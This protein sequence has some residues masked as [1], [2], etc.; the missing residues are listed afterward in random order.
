[1]SGHDFDGSVQHSAG[2][3]TDSTAT[4]RIMRQHNRAGTSGSQL[5]ASEP[6]QVD[7]LSSRV[8]TGLPAED[9]AVEAKGSR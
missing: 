9:A 4:D 6:D 5:T 1:M 8:P 3:V 2:Y 7:F